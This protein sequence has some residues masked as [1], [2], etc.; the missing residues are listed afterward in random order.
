MQPGTMTNQ[1]FLADN[2][3][4]RKSLAIENLEEAYGLFLKAFQEYAT[5]QNLSQKQI[6]EFQELIKKAY[7]EKKVAYFLSDKLEDYESY[8]NKAFTLALRGS[9]SE[10]SDSSQLDFAKLLYFRNKNHMIY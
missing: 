4:S 5:K 7:L 10:L 1:K 8:F 6:Q 2:P 3:I 9:L